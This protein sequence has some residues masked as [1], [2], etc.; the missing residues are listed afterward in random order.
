[1]DDYLGSNTVYPGTYWKYFATHTIDRQDSMQTFF[2][3]FKK[4]RYFLTPNYYNMISVDTHIPKK[5]VQNST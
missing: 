1:M 5:D 3:D 4:E 2:I